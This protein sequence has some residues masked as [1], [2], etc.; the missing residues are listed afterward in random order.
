MR[1]SLTILACAL[2]LLAAPALSWAQGVGGGPFIPNQLIIGSGSPPSYTIKSLGSFGLN[3]QCLTSQGDNLPPYWATCAAGG[4]GTGDFSSNTSTSVDGEIV[5]FSGTGGKTGKRATGTG[6]TLST[7][8]VFSVIAPTDDNI[9]IG[10][11]TTWQLKA[12]PDCTD[13]GGNHLNYTAASNALSCGT[14]GGGG[15]G[16][17]THTGN[18]TAGQLVIGNGTADEKVDTGCSTDGAGTLTCVRFKAALPTALAPGTTV[19]MDASVNNS[20]TLVPA[21]NFTLANPTN[22]QNGQ[23]ILL[24]IK[25]DGTGSRVITYDTKFRFGTGI[26]TAV[27]STGANKVD[28]LGFYY[29]STDD[30][31]DVVAFEN[32]H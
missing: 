4:G 6:L 19:T 23:K 32:G 16:T 3:T 2:A 15:S 22:P 9:V 21:Q 7:S 25:Q 13:T 24:R 5:L 12:I 8:G 10:N 1:R 26:A 29:D 11:G 20:F 18:L 14:S 27:L 30:R 28:Y 17:V 31:W